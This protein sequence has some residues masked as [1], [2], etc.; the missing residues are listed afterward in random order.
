MKVER[1]ISLKALREGL[2]LPACVIEQI[3]VR[4]PGKRN[5][6]IAN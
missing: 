3:L 4:I 5:E 1:V 2:K 6:P